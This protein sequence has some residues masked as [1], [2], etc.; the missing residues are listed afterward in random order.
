MDDLIAR[1]RERA[2]DPERNTDLGTR[3]F[4][5]QG[6]RIVLTRPPVSFEE[7]AQAETALGFPLP[8]LLRRLYRE[9]GDGD[10]GPGY[11]LPPLLAVVDTMRSL[12]AEED[13]PLAVL[14][15][16]GWGCSYASY[17]D[18]A[19][20][21]LP[22][23]HCDWDLRGDWDGAGA[24]FETLLGL[25][26]LPDKQAYRRLKCWPDG[27]SLEAFLRAWA[28]EEDLSGLSLPEGF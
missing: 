17:V 28:D 20:P 19:P 11:G 4:D 10:W 22:V 16:C 1:L 3:T 21:D 23:L 8:D 2:S 26:D 12:R 27:R 18:C 9:V 14:P 6:R 15:L 13:W 5:A 24:R 25:L 7:I